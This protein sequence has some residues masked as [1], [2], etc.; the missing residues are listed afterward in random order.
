MDKEVKFFD[1]VIPPLSPKQLDDYFSN[2]VEEESE[3]E[4]N[5][6]NKPQE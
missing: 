5:K 3:E 6:S 2:F 4:I 1:T